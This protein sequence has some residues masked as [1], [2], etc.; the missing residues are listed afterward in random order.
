MFLRKRWKVSR[1]VSQVICA[2]LSF[3][4]RLL[5]L[6]KSE[7]QA[8]DIETE[9]WKKVF[10]CPGMREFEMWSAVMVTER[11]VVALVAF[12]RS[13]L[14]TYLLTEGKS[15]RLADCNPSRTDFGLIYSSVQA[16]I[17]LFGGLVR[18]SPDSTC[19]TL[20]LEASNWEGLPNMT[21]PRYAFNPVSYG[22]LIYLCGG[23]VPLI[24]T[25]NPYSKSFRRISEFQLPPD[26]TDQW[27]TS[28]SLGNST[29]VI[30]SGRSLTQWSLTA[31]SFHSTQLSGLSP[32]WR[33]AYSP[34]APVVAGNCLYVVDCVMRVV[35]RLNIHTGRLEARLIDSN[36]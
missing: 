29:I 28:S 30:L 1:T 31:G 5:Y 25:F 32:S 8:F 24:E 16:A 27:E 3:P 15:R 21:S 34:S 11:E 22:A 10:E 4:N 12:R 20:F 18:N 13:C 33:S 19:G 7:V 9:H 36:R 14:E 23:G 26:P 2:Y 17:Y 35:Q 6:E